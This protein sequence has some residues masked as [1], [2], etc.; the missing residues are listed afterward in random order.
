MILVHWKAIMQRF[1]ALHDR[2]GTE[3]NGEDSCGMNMI[4]E[5]PQGC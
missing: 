2:K 3:G 1:R 5:I 4:G